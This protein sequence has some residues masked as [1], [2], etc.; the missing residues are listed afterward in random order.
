[1]ENKQSCKVCEKGLLIS[2]VEKNSVEY[3]GHSEAIPLHYSVCDTCGS[4][5]GSP[6]EVNK[7]KAEMGSFKQRI[8][9][10]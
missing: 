10:L 4:E 6:E 8:D 1:M 2:M 3:K 5:T 9:Q 7:N